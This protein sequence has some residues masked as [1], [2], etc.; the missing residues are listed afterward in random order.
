MQKIR[1]GFYKYLNM[2][3]T[4]KDESLMSIMGLGFIQ[5]EFH[6][7]EDYMNHMETHFERELKS[8]ESEYEKFHKSK[9]DKSEYS[10]EYLNHVQD[11]F[12]ISRNQ[13]T[14][15]QPK[16]NGFIPI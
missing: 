9:E 7:I 15:S 13:N 3:R 4:R 16:T 12:E 10:E 5:F 6:L 8:I 2:S 11:S 1:Y 14:N